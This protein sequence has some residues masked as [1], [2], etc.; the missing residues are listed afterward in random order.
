M[1]DTNLDSNKI[2]EEI[3]GGDNL[4]IKPVRINAPKPLE[5]K[6]AGTA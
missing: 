5:P 1:V 2:K 4:V 6:N 3:G